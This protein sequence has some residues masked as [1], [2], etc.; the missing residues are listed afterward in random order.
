M[1]RNAGGHMKRMH[2]QQETRETE[3][4]H[5]PYNFIYLFILKLF[6]HGD[7]SKYMHACIS[8]HTFG[9]HGDNEY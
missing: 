8:F 7:L 1:R 6:N 2:H 9:S 4:K 3:T 5:R